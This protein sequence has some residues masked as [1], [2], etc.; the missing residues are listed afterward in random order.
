MIILMPTVLFIGIS[1]ITGIQVLTP[2]GEER[3][4]VISVLAG[5][6]LDF[7]LNLVL[8]PRM[9]STGAAISTLLAEILVVIVQAG[10]LKGELKNMLQGIKLWKIMLPL[11]AA[12]I[13]GLAMHQM[14]S[15]TPFF[16]LL[17]TAIV[18]FGV[19]GAILLIVREEFVME[20][21]ESVIRRK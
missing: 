19:Y 15:M 21:L 7:A 6:V 3:K 10:Y 13:A 8:I 12:T 14:I 17:V 4:V 5:A 18:F 1:N 16:T 11:V 9:G 20:L 2:F